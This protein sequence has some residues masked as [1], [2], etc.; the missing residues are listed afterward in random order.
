MKT[1]STSKAKGSKESTMFTLKVTLLFM[2]S[3]LVIG[4]IAYQLVT[5][6]FYVGENSIFTMYLRSESNPDQWKHVMQWQFP[7]LFLRSLLIAFVLLPFVA[8][9]R[10]F[11]FKKCVGTLF[12]MVFVLTHLSSAAPSPG[13][14]EGIV[15][16]RPELM[17][18]K[19]FL[20]TQIEMILQSLIFAFGA[21][22]I[23]RKQAKITP[24]R[25][26]K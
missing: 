12:A 20:L 3:Y 21:A 16:M 23:I 11:S 26:D 19:V 14:I 1:G 9:L 2:V 15:Y 7:M 17:N 24:Q 8:A 6:Q 13:N 4:A 22:L 5:K 25:L 10:G 18:I